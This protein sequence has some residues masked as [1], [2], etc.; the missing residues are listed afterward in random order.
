MPA[1]QLMT[2]CEGPLALNDNAFEL[3]RDFLKPDGDRFF[4]QV[5]RLDD[6]LA[7]IARQP[8]YRAGTTLKLI[9]PFLKASGLTNALLQ[10]YSEKTMRLVPGAVEAYRFLH[11]QGFPIFEISTSYRQFAEAVGQKL[12]FAP[13]RIISTDLDL[14]RYQ[15]SPAEAERLGALKDEIAAL[16][17]I[18]IP[19]QAAK[20]EDLGPESRE[21]IGRL[22][23][24]FFEIIPGL[25]IGRLYEEV[26]PVGGPEKA[27]ALEDSLARTGVAQTGALYVGDS[28]TDVEAFKA[29]RLGGGAAVSFNGNRYA[30]NFAEFIVVANNAWPIPLLAAIFLRWGKDGLVE[31]STSSQAGHEKIVALPESMV[32]PIMMGLQ[33]RNFSF[34]PANAPHREKLIE[35]SAA[36]RARLRGEAVAALG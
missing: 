32:E 17:A 28:I 15:L 4:T 33:G 2:D 21:V 30:I 5:S 36:M 34:Y 12:G 14:D 31:L 20:P 26:N 11:T 3:C 1:I 9:L 7:D 27:R 22:E 24:I 6:Y 18:D 35:E 19:T 10:E 29:V 13:D 25:D 8:G 16:P 23:R